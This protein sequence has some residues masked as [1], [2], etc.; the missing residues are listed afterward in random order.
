MSEQDM[1]EGAWTLAWFAA[2]A[3]VFGILVALLGSM[4]P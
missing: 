4:L 1:R 3:G 2:F